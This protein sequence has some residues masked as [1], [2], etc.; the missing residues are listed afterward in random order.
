MAVH[1]FHAAVTTVVLT[2]AAEWGFALAGANA[3]NAHGV[4]DRPTQDIDLFSPLPGGPAAALGDIR[5]ALV[6]GGFAVTVTRPPAESGDFVAFTVERDG[7]SVS[8]DL[9]R[10]WRS[11]AP[12]PLQIGPVL[13]IEDLVAS[14]ASALVS[15]GEPRDFVDLAAALRRYARHQLMRMAF[16]RDPGL[17]VEDFSR[18][19]HLLDALDDREFAA[20]DLTVEQI[21]D[22]RHAF[23]DWPRNPAGDEAGHAAHRAAHPTDERA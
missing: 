5:A 12:V 19:G 2:A 10:D 22:V 9:A 18:A 14:K 17:R 20:Y 4:V 15:R 11:H 21:A 3:L 16:D 8:I 13:S 7:Q 6:A 23:R 1:P